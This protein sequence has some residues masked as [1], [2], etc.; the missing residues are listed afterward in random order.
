M[1][2]CVQAGGDIVKAGWHAC[3][4]LFPGIYIYIL[5]FQVTGSRR[6]CAHVVYQDS[7]AQY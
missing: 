6:A 4:N 1:V 7:M 2:S 5:M 3:Q